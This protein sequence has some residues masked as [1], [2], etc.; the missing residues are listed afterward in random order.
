MLDRN[1]QFAHTTR[2]CHQPTQ[3][4]VSPT[5]VQVPF[6]QSPSNRP[7]HRPFSI[8]HPFRAPLATLGRHSFLPLLVLPHTYPFARKPATEGSA[9][10]KSLAPFRVPFSALLSPRHSGARDRES[11]PGL[12]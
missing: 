3:V 6:V 5:P 10:R 8:S 11:I 9:P 4:H 1:H 7:F 2:R 12:S